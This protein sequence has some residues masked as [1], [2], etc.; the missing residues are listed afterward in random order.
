M[1]NRIE[2]NFVNCT[3]LYLNQ[4]I[5][6]NGMN[7]FYC[8]FIFKSKHWKDQG[9]Y[10]RVRILIATWIQYLNIV[11]SQLVVL[12][13]RRFY[14]RLKILI[15]I[16]FHTVNGNWLLAPRVALQLYDSDIDCIIDIIGLIS[17]TYIFSVLKLHVSTKY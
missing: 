13:F 14:H 5:G 7:K 1:Y 12:N 6:L 2:Y 4:C 10:I 16:V 8:S 15:T 9:C 17:I 11:R 3:C